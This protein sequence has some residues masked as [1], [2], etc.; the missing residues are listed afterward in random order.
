VAGRRGEAHRKFIRNRRETETNF[1][2]PEPEISRPG[3]EI[4][5]RLDFLLT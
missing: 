3:R 1:S 4:R 2:F 5:R